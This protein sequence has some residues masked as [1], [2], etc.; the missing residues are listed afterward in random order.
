MAEKKKKQYMMITLG[1]F[2]PKS[3]SWY[4]NG[5]TNIEGTKIDILTASFGFNQIINEPT[6]ILNNS[7]SC[8]NLIVT[9]Q[10]MITTK[11]SNRIRGSFFLSKQIVT[12]R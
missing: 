7:S 12:I 6:H 9:S 1:D 10:P 3:N 5:N 4:A 8:I 2:D 11:S